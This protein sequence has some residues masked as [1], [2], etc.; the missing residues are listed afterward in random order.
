MYVEDF[1]DFA[2]AVDDRVLDHRAR[3]G[4]LD[5]R[6]HPAGDA[7]DPD[8]ILA[9]L[10]RRYTSDDD[11]VQVPHAS[12]ADLDE[13]ADGH[14]PAATVIRQ[15]RQRTPDGWGRLRFPQYELFRGLIEG[16]QRPNAA[17]DRAFRR[18]YPNLA[19]AGDDP[20]EEVRRA[21][22]GWA[23]AAL[24]FFFGW[25]VRWW[26][27]RRW[28]RRMAGWVT[29]LYDAI[30]KDGRPA[31]DVFE[32][33]EWLIR[34]HRR[35]VLLCAIIA[36]LDAA[37][38]PR[39]SPWRR[40][41]RSGFVLLLTRPSA[42]LLDRLMAA[43][44]PAHVTVVAAL[45]VPASG[46]RTL[47]QAANAIR[48]RAGR[49][50]VATTG[51][52]RHA[53]A[54][55][56]ASTHRCRAKTGRNGFAVLETITTA[57]LAV[58]V[59]VTAAITIIGP[60][61]PVPPDVTCIGGAAAAGP[62]VNAGSVPSPAEAR[63]RYDTDKNAIAANNRKA[64]AKERQGYTVKTIVYIGSGVAGE[65][66]RAPEFNT[67][68]PELSGLRI[69]QERLNELADAEP[70]SHQRLDGNVY[71]HLDVREAGT[72]FANA[73]AIARQVA[74]QSNDKVLGV[75]G[76][77]ESRHET[78]E[79][80][81]ILEEAGLPMIGI[82]ATSEDLQRS[83]LYRQV[84]WDNPREA[85]LA[86]DFA[87][88]ANIVADQVTPGICHPASHAIVIGDP[89][90]DY[91]QTLARDFTADFRAS[92][93]LW[94]GRQGTPQGSVA[95]SLSDMAQA[96]CARLA[97]Q[98]NGRTVIY[99]AGRA[100]R[101]RDF[102]NQ[103]KG[104]SSCPARYTVVAGDDVTTTSTRADQ[105]GQQFPGVTVFHAAHALGSAPPSSAGRDFKN[106]YL[107]HYHMDAWYDGWLA[108]LAYDALLTMAQAINEV[109]KGGQQAGCGRGAT[110]NRMADGVGRSAGVPGATG[111]I[112]YL[113]PSAPNATA[114]TVPIDKRFLMIRDD[115]IRRPVVVMECG[116]RAVN[117]VR[118]RWGPGGKFACAR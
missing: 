80:Q 98:R 75:V 66:L 96:V 78:L 112:L 17:R 116:R 28:R 30:P 97:D 71:I 117:D 109:C 99:W 70:R 2:A 118:T 77:G 106:L 39:L 79:A 95:E 1:A 65:T 115:G 61:T 59:I 21:L 47:A 14:D 46:P 33:A 18:V 37:Y 44:E 24:A 34:D 26:F 19:R 90:D 10:E 68:L 41:R 113:D 88:K 111:N 87:R 42:T 92:E 4:T 48:N 55:E 72:S 9:A 85:Q 38:T 32:R 45:D 5:V 76:L 49:V 8:V 94:D 27:G 58:A 102:L 54:D 11:R 82:G 103:A 52:P 69:A 93:L 74:R 57:T 22:P 35:L 86:A 29:R 56:L 73:P 62:A 89:A 51:V 114:K 25:V 83:P 50:D 12:V 36:D 31:R 13:G 20:A 64:D 40:R 7:A 107:D 108:P 43:M 101:L 6:I 84:A 105:F 100:Q 91:S 3:R 16:G 60:P 15:L 53:T 67:V 63:R 104:V 23:R 81:H 110:Q